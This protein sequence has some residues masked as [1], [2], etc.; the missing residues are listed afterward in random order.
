MTPKTVTPQELKA[1]EVGPIKMDEP[2]FSTCP[3]CLSGIEATTLE[4]Q[5]LEI[6]KR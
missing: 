4:P 1:Q 3:T 6:L 5:Y 2:D